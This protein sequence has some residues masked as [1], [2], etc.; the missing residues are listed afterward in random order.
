MPRTIHPDLLDCLRR[1]NPNVELRTEIS[2]PDVG[3]T[4]RRKDQFEGAGR[5]SIAPAASMVVSANG[6]LQLAPTG[7]AL[8]DFPGI[9]GT[10]AF[11]LNKEDPSRR[12]KGLS[13]LVDPAF[14]RSTLKTFTA[15]IGRSGGLFS[16]I[17]TDFELQIYRVTKTPGVIQTSNPGG[18]VIG[19][20]KF[21]QYVF[22]P[23]LSSA[24]L[25]KA[26]N[27][28]W[29]GNRATLAFDLSQYGVVVDNGPSQAT[30]P[31]QVGELPNYYF[32]VRSVNAPNTTALFFWCQD[33]VTSA[34]VAGV[35]TFSKVFWG[36]DSDTQ[37]WSPTTAAPTN[38]PS[39]T[40][41][42]ES[43]AATSQAV[44]SINLGRAPLAGTVGRVVFERSLPP[45]TVATLELSTAGSGGPWTLV[46][47]GDAP[48]L[49]QQNYHLRLTETSDVTN[50]RSSPGV[51]AFG[52]EFRTITDIS[53]ESILSLPAREI[54]TPFLAASIPQASIKV[55][56]IGS[57]D[58]LDV[59]TSLGSSQSPPKLEAEIYLA[60]RHP[61]ITR[62]KWL[63]LERMPVTN[64]NPSSSS[65]DFTLL[66]YASKLKRKIPGKVETINTVHTV[67]AGSDATKIIVSPNLLGPAPGDNTLYDGKHYYMRV[68]K[69]SAGGLPQGYTQEIQGNTG[70]AQIDFT[71]NLPAAL[72]TG[73]TIEVHSG[74]FNTQPINWVDYDPADVWWEIMTLYANPPIQ[75]ERIG[76]GF[77]PRGGRPPHVT[78]RAPG[79]PTTQ[80]KLKVTMRLS[81]QESCDQLLDQVSL[82]MGGATIEIDGQMCF[83]QVYPLRAADGTISVPLPPVAAVFDLRDYTGLSTPPGL[84]ERATVLSANYG[85]NKSAVNPD[86]FPSKTTVVVDNDALSWLTQ[87]DLEDV[88]SS[89]LPDNISRWLYN[90]ADEGLYLATT[91]G[92]QIVRAISTGKRVFSLQPIEVQPQLIP[93]DPI[94]LITDA[95]TDYDPA[96][97]VAVKGWLAIRGVT[98]RVA[99]QGRLLG[100]YILG[101]AEN[102][103]Q[104]AGGASGALTGLGTQPAPPIITVS[105]DRDGF[106][107]INSTGDLATASHKIAY[108]SGAAP[109]AALVRAQAPIAGQIVP[110]YAP[111]TAYAPGD[112]V[113]VGAFA[114]SA[115][116]LESSPLAI[117]S[118]T[119]EGVDVDI[120]GRL[121]RNKPWDDGDY[122]IRGTTSNGLT[123]HTGALESGLKPVN[124]LLAKTLAADP[125]NADSV[126]AGTIRRIPLVGAT[127]SSGNVD[128]GGV[129]WVNKHAG[130]LPSR[131]PSQDGTWSASG[132]TLTGSATL[133]NDGD[134]GATAFHTDSAIAG[135]FV[136]VDFGI[137]RLFDSLRVYVATSNGAANWKVRGSSDGSTWTDL[138]TN[139]IPDRVGWNAITFGRASWRFWRLELTNTPGPGPF[140][141]E[142][143]LGYSLGGGVPVSNEF[144]RTGAAA[145]LERIIPFLDTGALM[146]AAA[147][148]SGAKFVNRLL[149]KAL[150]ADPDS[151]DGA[152]DGMTYRRLANVNGS[153]QATPISVTTRFSCFLFTGA[154]QSIGNSSATFL[155]W[156][157]HLWDNGGLHNDVTN[158]SEIIV[159]TGGNVGV[160]L[161]Q[162]IV[163]FAANA[164]GQRTVE[165]WK[166]NSNRMAVAT[167]QATAAGVIV[168][169][170]SVIDVAPAVGDFYQVKVTQNS[171]GAL[172][173]SGTDSWFAATHL[174]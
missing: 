52:I 117:A 71:P 23:L 90:S 82:I 85:V 161:L 68:Q 6:A 101:L 164:T 129:A 26:A 112:T 138:A 65:E 10:T 105:F 15:R 16:L 77:L 166:N 41:T 61:S 60:S 98:V 108:G 158:N 139:F 53:V 118:F 127:D 57:R 147:K 50:H 84:E 155:N 29:V 7:I 19:N 76:Q 13:W 49:A 25:Y 172:N 58:Y 151:L 48:A 121:K 141:H 174:W 173:A 5:V 134:A 20:V 149:A 128:L 42:V 113:Y 109:S 135:A 120:L 154:A 115:N 12:L 114:Y 116:G 30:H 150:A 62:D 146:R 33:L 142:V 74:I 100:I 73:D 111:G 156:T 69:T 122:T 162:T 24:A 3:Q 83:V 145:L 21:T 75:P 137:A 14:V 160:W 152:P 47:H 163:Q 27:I 88:G 92:V 8:A 93:G 70:Q 168:I 80:A 34:T 169:P 157:S 72:S 55:L 94:I 130:N 97:G 96:S 140:V 43:F 99:D 17:P 40:I 148:E 9:T 126:L 79:D 159:P 167:L 171:G 28:V 123:L 66:S 37:E 81:E 144:G 45:G 22:T 31:D 124:R 119:R 54:A 67:Q 35:G 64:R 89:E 131:S 91:V 56:R 107:I 153:N 1:P 46:S 39:S 132:V 86:S 4:Y 110:A 103:T 102:V 36:R 95:Y 133:I 165:I 38:P 104:V 87:Q 2:A 78:D 51:T 63:R 11:D 18:Q 106:I 136:Q 59:A 143:E 170:I 32:V 125:D 44:Y